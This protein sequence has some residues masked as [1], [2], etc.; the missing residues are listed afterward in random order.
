MGGKLLLERVPRRPSVTVTRRDMSLSLSLL[1]NFGAWE[2]T[3]GSFHA[4][5]HPIN[6]HTRTAISWTSF[7]SNS[8][9]II[10]CP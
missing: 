9:H 10:T 1:V 7:L 8:L 4:L 6:P 3:M 5:A 2:E